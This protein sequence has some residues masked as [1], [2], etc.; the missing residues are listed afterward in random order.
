MLGLVKRE[1][2]AKGI[3]E[4]FLGA[5]GS[6]GMIF[7]IFLGADMLNSA[8]ALSQMPAQLATVVANSGLAPLAII[9]AILLMYIALGAVMDELSMIL[10][11]IPVLFPAVIGLDLFGLNPTEK[12]IWF[13]ILVLGVVQIGLVAPP[14]G[15]NVYVVN[16]LARDVPWR[17]PIAGCCPSWFRTRYVSCCCSCFLPS[18][19]RSCACSPEGNAW[20][21]RRHSRHCGAAGRPGGG[22]NLVTAARSANGGDGQA[23]AGGEALPGVATPGGPASAGDRRGGRA[24]RPGAER[25]RDLQNASRLRPAG[26]RTQ[27]RRHAAQATR[28]ATGATRRRSATGVLAAAVVS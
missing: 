18:R 13:G 6:S 23:D 20:P 11:T 24:H 26:S 2:D 12:A 10:L 5:A 16:G 3:R 22:G 9:G 8:L 4:S 27:G 15:L 7:M 28:E 19:C 21:P 1:L 17:R 14:V 25:A